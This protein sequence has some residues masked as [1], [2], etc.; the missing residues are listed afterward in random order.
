MQP[1]EGFFNIGFRKFIVSY[2]MGHLFK[3]QKLDLE[4]HL[5]NILMAHRLLTA[6]QP[7]FSY[8][9]VMYNH[10]DYKPRPPVLPL[11]SDL[12]EK[13]IEYNEDWKEYQYGARLEIQNYL[14][15][16]V[17][18]SQVPS[19]IILMLPSHLHN[20]VLK[21]LGKEIEL[22]STTINEQC[23]LDFVEKHQTS[24]DKLNE[25]VLLNLIS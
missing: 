24:L 15:N 16:V 12:S 19:D 2:L 10:S 6:G 9:G 22:F 18:I 25:Q 3:H 13:M 21:K 7:A 14:I 1:N 8:K 17:N 11:H 4:K 23:R 20:L 5:N